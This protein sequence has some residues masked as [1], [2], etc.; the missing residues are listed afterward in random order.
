M[1]ERKM[2]IFILSL[3]LLQQIGS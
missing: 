2:F 1:N 3:K